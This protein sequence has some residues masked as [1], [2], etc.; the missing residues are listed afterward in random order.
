MGQDD[1]RLMTAMVLLGAEFKR[2]DMTSHL[3]SLRRFYS[4]HRRAER[5]RR[6]EEWS[7]DL[8]IEWLCIFHIPPFESIYPVRA[9]ASSLCIRCGHNTDRDP[10]VRAVYPGG[11]LYYCKC[12]ARWIVEEA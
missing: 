2:R 7:Q 6:P 10:S 5:G 4:E 3:E 12:G 9:R 1:F 8:V 11:T